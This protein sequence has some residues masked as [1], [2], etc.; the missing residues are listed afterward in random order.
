MASKKNAKTKPSLFRRLALDAS[1]GISFG[2]ASVCLAFITTDE[3]KT[4]TFESFLIAGLIVAITLVVGGIAGYM[5]SKRM[6]KRPK[7]ARR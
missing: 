3:G 5:I 2:I 1:V 6:E 4:G 7:T